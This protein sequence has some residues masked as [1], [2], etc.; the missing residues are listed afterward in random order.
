MTRK[1]TQEGFLEKARQAHGDRYSYEK[2][3]YIGTDTD[4]IITCHVHGDFLST[5]YRH[6]RGSGCVKCA[7]EKTAKKRAL[8]NGQFVEKAHKVHKGKYDYS[9]VVYVNTYTSV[10]IICPE[11]GPFMQTP[12]SHLAGSNCPTCDSIKTSR[13]FSK[14]LGHFLNKAVEVHG[15]KYDY[16][17]F[18]YTKSGAKS[19]IICQKHGEFLQS[20]NRH[21]AG[22]GCRKCASERVGDVCRK[23]QEDF[24][25]DAVKRH[26]NL[27]DYSETVYKTIKIKVDIRCPIHGIFRQNPG[28]HTQG[29]GCPACAISGYASNK[30]GIIYVLTSD[31]LTK[32]GISNKSGKSRA[33]HV[34]R[35]SGIEFTEA[36]SAKFDDGTIAPSIENILLQELRSKYENPV[37]KFN[38][39]T[40]CFY[41]VDYEELIERLGALI[42]QSVE[43]STNN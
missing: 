12:A 23:T 39:Y 17:K 9:P 41:D 40:E 28:S 26:G 24:L 3:K 34:S 30:P 29:Q 6:V 33:K 13:R 42:S 4:I 21:L 11:H 18:V 1:L 5:P 36:F 15:D 2:S 19:I 27:Y 7:T 32:V 16:S 43:L 10:E 14:T 31:K 35:E 38:G 8:T 20:S 25:E 22:E 37:D